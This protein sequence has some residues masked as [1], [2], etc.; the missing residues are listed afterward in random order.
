MDASVI[1][2]ARDAAATLPRT[3]AALAGQRLEG[4]YEVLV[5]DDGSSDGTA[6]VVKAAGEGFCLLQQDARGPAQA[7]NRGVAEASGRALA[8]TDADCF[9][10]SDWLAAG[11]AALEHADLVQGKVLPD[12][13]VDMGPFDRSLWV[14]SEVGLYETANLF[15]RRETFDRS[16]GFEEWLRPE[17]GKAMAE[18]V[19]FG[20]KARRLGARTAYSAE[21]LVHHAVFRQTARDYVAERRRLR[22]FP[23]MAAKMPELRSELFFARVFLTSRAAAVDMA[24]AGLMAAA[25]TRSPYPLVAAAP[26]A[27]LL[28]RR[29]RSDAATVAGVEMAADV[30][31]MYSLIRGSVTARSPLF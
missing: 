21:A 5:V 28:A 7:R 23:A 29:W 25:A 15:V 13:E 22:Y 1:V 10:A 18:D 4:S 17:L 20:W 12:P 3:L 11:L 6:D 9:P 24:T 14:T 8:F 30:V 2:P 19:W 26:Y 27:V 16:G 31:G